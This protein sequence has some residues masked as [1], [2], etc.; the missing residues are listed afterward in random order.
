MKCGARIIDSHEMHIIQ[1]KP[2]PI[3]QPIAGDKWWLKDADYQVTT[4]PKGHTDAI[5]YS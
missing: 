3:I 4:D 5:L 1:A 2:T